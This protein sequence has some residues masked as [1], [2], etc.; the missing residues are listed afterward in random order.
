[1]RAISGHTTLAEMLFLWSLASLVASATAFGPNGSNLANA[2]AV[3]TLDTLRVCDQLY[4]QY[5]DYMA[6]DPLGPEAI[7]TVKN[8]HIYKLINTVYWNDQNS[9]AFRAACA[10]FPQDAEQVSG[11]V[12]LLNQF[13]DVPYAMKSGGHNPA[14]GF[15]AVRQGVLI[16]FEPNLAGTVRTQDGKHFIVGPGARWVRIS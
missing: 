15:S 7:K 11:V 12:R 9:Y 1:M 16:S 3:P 6:Y 5:P 13:P 10:F 4:K 14:P 2:T 8:A